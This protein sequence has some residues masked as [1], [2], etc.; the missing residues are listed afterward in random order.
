[1]V[2]PKGLANMH[3]WPHR[4][5]ELPFMHHYKCWCDG[6]YV[7]NQAH[8]SNSMPLTTYFRQLTA[9]ACSICAPQGL[10]TFQTDASLCRHMVSKHQR[11]LCYTCLRVGFFPCTLASRQIEWNSM[12]AHVPHSCR[13]FMWLVTAAVESMVILSCQAFAYCIECMQLSLLLLLVPLSLCVQALYL[14]CGAQA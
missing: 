1:M 8:P 14:C 7:I 12:C 10:N 2:V 9:R 5:S 11:Y 4:V 6:I 3:D 13:T